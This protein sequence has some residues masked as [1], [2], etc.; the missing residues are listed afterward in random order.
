MHHCLSFPLWKFLVIALIGYLYLTGPTSE[1]AKTAVRG[2][3][4]EFTKEASELGT[5][6]LPAHRQE[7]APSQC[8]SF[9]LVVCDTSLRKCF[10]H[11]ERPEAFLYFSVSGRKDTLLTGPSEGNTC[12]HNFLRVIGLKNILRKVLVFKKS[13]TPR[14]RPCVNS[15]SVCI[16]LVLSFSHSRLPSRRAFSSLNFCSCFL[17]FFKNLFLFIL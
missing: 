13:S 17:A 8:G 9:S 6:Q 2:R 10:L 15:L 7:S 4:F 5:A 16:M 1:R 14:V 12:Y 11:Q 3:C